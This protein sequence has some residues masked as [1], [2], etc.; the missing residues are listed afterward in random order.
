MFWELYFMQNKRLF[1]YVIC[2]LTVCVC[3]DW[4]M[5][6]PLTVA[7]ENNIPSFTSKVTAS[8][9]LGSVDDIN[10]YGINKISGDHTTECVYNN[11]IKRELVSSARATS[12]PIASVIA[13]PSNTSCTTYNPLVNSA[14]LKK[15]PEEAAECDSEEFGR[16]VNQFCEVFSRSPSGK[17]WSTFNNVLVLLIERLSFCRCKSGFEVLCK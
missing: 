9:N 2:F 12:P 4:M 8:T 17:P 7:G 3:I 14:P 6:D 15:V 5:D 16:K 1:V 11:N 13:S 10:F